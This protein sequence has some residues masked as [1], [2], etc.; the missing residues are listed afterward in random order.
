MTA[1]WIKRFNK[2]RQKSDLKKS[3]NWRD[4][5]LRRERVKK[6]KPKHVGYSVLGEG[7]TYFFDNEV[8][9]WI[10]QSLKTK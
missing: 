3:D 10:K 6:R 2:K 5:P 9:E 8:K 7:Q 4:F 1:P